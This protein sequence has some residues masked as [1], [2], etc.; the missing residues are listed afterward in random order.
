MQNAREKYY[1]GRV[2]RQYQQDRSC[3]L[4][5][6]TSSTPPNSNSD[7][8]PSDDEIEVMVKAYATERKERTERFIEALRRRQWDY[9]EGLCGSAI[10]EC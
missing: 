2:Q 10:R 8:V 9:L 6:L 3:V 4:R 1:K 5:N 7:E